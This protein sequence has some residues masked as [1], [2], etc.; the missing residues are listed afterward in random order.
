M[1]LTRLL[2]SQ[3]LLSCM[4]VAV[5]T[6]AYADDNDP[7]HQAERRAELNK[8]RANVAMQGAMA[9]SQAPGM[10]FMP[11]PRVQPTASSTNTQQSNAQL[12]SASQNNSPQNRPP[13][14]NQ[15]HSQ[16]TIQNAPVGFNKPNNP[17][18][19]GSTFTRYQGSNQPQ[20]QQSQGSQSWGS[21][22]DRDLDRQNGSHNQGFNNNVRFNNNIGFNNTT[23]QNRDM[24]FD[25]DDH[26][27]DPH[28]NSGWENH[29]R[30]PYRHGDG[31]GYHVRYVQNWPRH[32]TWWEH[33]WRED[34][35]AIDPYWFA[36]ITS[37]AV[38]QT[39]SDAEVAQAI[40]DNNLRQQLIYDADVRQQMIDSGYPADQV[41]YP[42][43]D[44]GA[45][46]Y[47]LQYSDGQNQYNQN[48]YPAQYGQGQVTIQS[49][50]T[51]YYPP[52]NQPAPSYSTSNPTSYVSSS[53]PLYTGHQNTNLASGEQIANLNANKNALFFC[54][55]GNKPAAI[56]A[57]H[58]IQS[59]DMSVWKTME[60]FD[61]CSAWATP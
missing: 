29:Y 55:A 45:D 39:W 9:S 12:S 57:F 51:G 49:S 31:G 15:P 8:Q 1:T 59:T 60:R 26:R 30:M 21:H 18:N 7:Q 34:Y 56:Q 14:N 36:L 13:Q 17:A 25:H 6:S 40:N 46:G 53:S 52:P 19:T 41:D 23:D 32:Y 48:P 27:G 43:N 28:F 44:F 4:V 54:T 22:A 11:I 47:G 24:R 37:I 20:N 33:G 5:V 2:S 42:E 35:Q 16:P 3:L 50:Q 58:Q 61:R 10:H 38:A